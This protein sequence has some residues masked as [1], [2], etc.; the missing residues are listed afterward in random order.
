MQAQLVDC[1][2][3]RQEMYGEGNSFS[4]FPVTQVTISQFCSFFLFSEQPLVN[5]LATSVTH[6]PGPCR[7]GKFK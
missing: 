4:L 3:N 1:F 6:M 5:L 2:V 7:V